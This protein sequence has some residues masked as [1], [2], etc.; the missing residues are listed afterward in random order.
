MTAH[1]VAILAAAAIA[2]TATAVPATAQVSD[3]IVLNIM[4]ECARIDDPTARLACYDNNIRNAGGNPRSSVPGAMARPQGGPGAPITGAG[5][6]GFGQEDVR[7]P[8]RFATPAGEVDEIRSRVAGVTQRAPGQYLI[9]LEDGAQWLFV[10]TVDF[11]YSPPR[12][13]STI[14]I[15]RGAMDSFLMRFDNQESV[16]IR[17][18]R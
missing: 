5:P 8:E 18:V 12:R 16:R 7:T 1:R 17:R 14:E 3:E 11:S 4:R 6:Q 9:E 10:D 2:A 15:R 13:G